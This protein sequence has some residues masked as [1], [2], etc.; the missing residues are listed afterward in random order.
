MKDITATDAARN[1]SDLLDAVEHR[2]E[3]FVVRRGGK[4]IA[5]ISPAIHSSGGAVKKLLREFPPDKNWAK[6]LANVRAE[7][8]SEERPW[9]A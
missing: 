4:P 8:T 5:R 2:N 7:L 6:D 1:F 3:S 9:N